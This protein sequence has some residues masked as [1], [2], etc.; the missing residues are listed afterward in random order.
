MRADAPSCGAP[1]EGHLGR[2]P[3]SGRAEVPRSTPASSLVE[4]RFGPGTARRSELDL[5]V[6]GAPGRCE[7]TRRC[8]PWDVAQE[9]A[10]LTGAGR[11]T[12]A[13]GHQH[14][15]LD[16]GHSAGSVAYPLSARPPECLRVLSQQQHPHPSML[17]PR[18]KRSPSGAG[19]ELESAARGS[20]CQSRGVPV[21]LMHEQAG[22][23][24]GRLG[25][26]DP[27][28][29]HRDGESRVAEEGAHMAPTTPAPMTPT[30]VQLQ[31]EASARATPGPASVA[32][33]RPAY[34]R[35]ACFACARI[36]DR[37]RSRRG[38]VS[39]STNVIAA[40]TDGC[41]RAISACSA[42][43]TAR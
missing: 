20:R 2:R 27:W 26:A 29:V 12:L 39:R 4:Q 23:S 6:R 15:R 40:A 33:A 16:H 14:R 3:S 42:C 10:G 38:S 31:P 8:P 37:I 21:V 24:P 22:R 7:S 1:A 28:V 19:P 32:C 25:T 18:W 9:S 17:E 41:T 5:V 35:D 34:A 11:T 43:A 13:L 30:D 36:S